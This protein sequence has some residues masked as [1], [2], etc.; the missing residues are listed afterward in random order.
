LVRER[1]AHGHLHS[2]SVNWGSFTIERGR[3]YR[4]L[5]I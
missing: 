4:S 2:A 3:L 1:L 5:A